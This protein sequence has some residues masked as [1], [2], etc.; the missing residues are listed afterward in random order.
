MPNKLRYMKNKIRIF[1]AMPGTTMGDDAPW[2]KPSDIISEFFDKIR[3]RVES[4]TKISTELIIEKEKKVT[5]PNIHDSMF[6]EARISD[7]YIADLTGYNPNVFLELGVRWALRDKITIPVCQ[8]VGTI[9]LPFN[10]QSSRVFPYSSDPK[11][12]RNAIT[13]ISNVIIR[14]LNDDNHCDSPVRRNSDLVQIKSSE[15]RELNAKIKDLE[16]KRGEDYLSAANKASDAETKISLLRSAIETNPYLID[17]YINLG[18]ELRKQSKYNE[19]IEVLKKGLIIENSNYGLFQNL[20]ISYGKIGELELSVNNLKNADK[21]KPNDPEILSNL[22]GALRRL[23]FSNGHQNVEW[24]ILS[25]ALE[26]YEMA[27]NIDKNNT[28]GLLNVAKLQLLLERI[29]PSYKHKAE[30]YL[31][32]IK[33]LSLAALEDDI[34]EKYWKMFDLGDTLILLGEYEEGKKIYQEA[35][36]SIPDDYKDSVMKSVTSSLSELFD[37][38]VLNTDTMSCIES[39]LSQY[40]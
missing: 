30:S 10:V 39:L 24:S 2:N 25:E 37:I 16:S 36:N 6:N 4:E 12:L 18:I 11:Q 19:S 34:N 20:G 13:E 26:K 8:T 40:K 17:A 32:K 22:G 31:R 33:F 27:A 3:E 21:I 5:T 28:Y 15:L 35:Y 14:E 23:S 29:D 9:P 7:V 1:V 38:G